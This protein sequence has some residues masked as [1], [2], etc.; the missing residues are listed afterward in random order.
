VGRESIANAGLS[1]IGMGGS[2]CIYGVPAEPSIA[3]HKNKGPYNFNL[4]VHQWPT[5][6]RERAAMEP[7]CE[8]VRAGKLRA[9]EFITHEF[10]VERIAEAVEAVNGGEALKVLLRY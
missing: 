3:I 4:F 2:I 6:W 10:P 1:L 5:R 9:A 8:W 7:L